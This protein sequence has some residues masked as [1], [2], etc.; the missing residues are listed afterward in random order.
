[1]LTLGKSL[2][3]MLEKHLENAGHCQTIYPHI[4][5]YTQNNFVHV[6]GAGVQASPLPSFDLLNFKIT[7]T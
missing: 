3:C 2:N 4:V 7:K 5:T 1:M 6:G